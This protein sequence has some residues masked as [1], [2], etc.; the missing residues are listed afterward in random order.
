MTRGTRALPLLLGGLLL[1]LLGAAWMSIEKTGY[2]PRLVLVSG[3]LLLIVFLIRHAAEIRFLFLEAHRRSEAGP[4]TTLFLAALVLILAALLAARLT[5]PID[6]TQEKV[7]SLS[8][9]SRSVL[10]ALQG[11]VHL[12]G[13]FVDASPQWDLARRYLE[14]YEHSSH[15]LHISLSDPDREPGRARALGVDQAG[16]IVATYAEARSQIRELSEEGI[17]NGILRIMEGRPRRVGFLQRHG[18]PALALGG[19][20]GITAWISALREVNVVAEEVSLLGEDEIL[21]RIDALLIVHPRHPLYPSE[22]T[23]IRRFLERGGRVGLWLE[24]GDSTGLEPY[25]AFHSLRILPGTVR[26]RGRIAQ[27]LGLGEWATALVGAPAHP[28]TA[29]LGTFAVAQQARPLQIISPHPMSLIIE[30]LLKTAKHSRDGPRAVEVVA[31]AGSATEEILQT[32]VQAIATALEW[33]IPVG[34][35]WSSKPDSLGLPPI[36]P[37]AR[38]LVFGDASLVTNRYIGLGSN[39]TLA[40][41]AVHWLTSQERFLGIGRAVPRPARL[42][43]GRQGLRVVLYAVEFGVPLLLALAGLLVSLRRRAGGA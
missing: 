40:L 35:E 9:E 20:E 15:R 38:L 33:E 12:D 39:R 22:T 14:L 10:E 4:T 11:P 5:L 32:G 1:L 43:L 27:G 2:L 17:I 26:D 7:N 19:E 16:V 8:A 29:R 13:F 24:P 21:D 6:L 37:R 31:E 41:N 36:K 34:A 25:L 42:R 18:E 30:P 3:A 23:L 28:V